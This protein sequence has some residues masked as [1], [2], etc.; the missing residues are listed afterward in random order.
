MSSAEAERGLV[1]E[2]EDVCA[3]A[4]AARPSHSKSH[5]SDAR[6]SFPGLKPTLPAPCL[7]QSLLL[8]PD[9]TPLC[10][11]VCVFVCV[12]VWPWSPPR[13]LSRRRQ[14]SLVRGGAAGEPRGRDARCLAPWRGTQLS[15]PHFP[16]PDC[17]VTATG[18]QRDFCL[19]LPHPAGQ[20]QSCAGSRG[21]RGAVAV[22]CGRRSPRW[23]RIERSVPPTL[24][25]V[26][27]QRALA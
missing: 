26:G 9:R 11:R 21:P 25:L 14:H 12:C 10:M 22:A 18:G 2:R 4:A 23:G 5:P 8:G 27:T 19:A 17:R 13:S 7:H 1:Q 20:S 16:E 15:P 6:R 24:H 3:T